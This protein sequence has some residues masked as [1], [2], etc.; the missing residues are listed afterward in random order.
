MFY[1]ADVTAAVLLLLLLLTQSA[2]PS[3]SAWDI[4]IC[5]FPSCTTGPP[6]LPFPHDVLPRLLLP[7]FCRCSG[8]SGASAMHVLL[9]CFST[10]DLAMP[11]TC[12]ICC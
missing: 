6:F 11:G 10:A 12:F 9:L 1:T 5:L 2:S 8:A 4:E 7:L 3:R